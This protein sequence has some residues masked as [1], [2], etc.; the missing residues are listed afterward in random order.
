MKE[1]E[2]CLSFP[3]TVLPLDSVIIDGLGQ[4]V[5]LLLQQVPRQVLPLL[6]LLVQEVLE[7]LRL[8]VQDIQLLLGLS[9][10]ILFSRSC[11][12]KLIKF[13][14]QCLSLLQKICEML[15]L[16]SHYYFS[17]FCNFVL[18]IRT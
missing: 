12:L 6:L 18:F 3:L 8:F 9:K 2:N 13:S 14:L 17:I 16:F 5:K 1:A 4:G 11:L 15:L 7:V 10:I